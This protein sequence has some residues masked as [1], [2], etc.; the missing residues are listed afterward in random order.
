M[1][2]FQKV[3]GK[4]CPDC[5]GSLV[6]ILHEEVRDSVRYYEEYIECEDCNYSKKLKSLI[7][8]DKEF[9]LKL[10]Q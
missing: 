4:P 10:Q 9:N 6:K 2:K 8:R 7:K 3:I 1:A 5:G